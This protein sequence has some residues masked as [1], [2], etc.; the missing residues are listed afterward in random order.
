MGLASGMMFKFLLLLD[1]L[2]T[3]FIASIDPGIAYR[4]R[5]I[6]SPS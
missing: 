6:G 4:S 1:A 2:C 3:A 5:D